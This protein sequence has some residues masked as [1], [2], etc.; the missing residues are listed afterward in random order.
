[1]SRNTYCNGPCKYD[2]FD[3]K[4][5]K[6]NKCVGDTLSSN[7]MSVPDENET[8]VDTC[9]EFQK[10]DERPTNSSG[11][12]ASDDNDRR[13]IYTMEFKS[14]KDQKGLYVSKYSI[15]IRYRDNQTLAVEI[16]LA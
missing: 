2:N 12:T 10:V 5:V 4:S 14:M 11:T 15:D 7:D 16:Y 9:Q 13:K 6:L 3:L 8:D 1:M